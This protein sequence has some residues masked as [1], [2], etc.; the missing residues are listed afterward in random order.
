LHG[1][2]HEKK[3]TVI[4]RSAWSAIVATLAQHEAVEI[5]VAP[6]PKSAV[7]FSSPAPPALVI[8][9]PTSETGWSSDAE[10]SHMNLAPWRSQMPGSMLEPQSHT[11]I[12]H[13][14]G[15]TP[16]S[17]QLPPNILTYCYDSRMVYVTPDEDYDVRSFC[18]S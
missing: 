11:A 9:P 6:P 17:S 2:Q 8:E 16:K 4:G 12:L 18:P 1:N 15:I 7:G 13:E 5:R 3:A 10:R 14:K